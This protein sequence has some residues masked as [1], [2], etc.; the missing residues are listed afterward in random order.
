MA[1]KK[2]LLKD[3]HQTHHN[4][5]CTDYPFQEEVRETFTTLREQIQT[6]D[7]NEASFLA[8]CEVFE[9]AGQPLCRYSSAARLQVFGSL[10]TP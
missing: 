5:S 4:A 3:H 8:S 1:R 10:C 6:I 9:S 2:R 7:R